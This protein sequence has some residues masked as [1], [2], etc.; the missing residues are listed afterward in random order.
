MKQLAQDSGIPIK[1]LKIVSVLCPEVVGLNN[2]VNVKKAKEYYESNKDFI[3]EIEADSLDNLKKIKLANEIVI[4]NLDIA[5]KKRQNITTKEETEYLQFLG[6]TISSILKAKLVN[7][8]PIKIDN[9]EREKRK[10]VCIEFYNSIVSE[11]YKQ[12]TS[13]NKNVVKQ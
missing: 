10:A 5:N 7:E 3:T 11:L 8:L 12:L 6:L 4:Q 13:R 2:K 1:H 9:T